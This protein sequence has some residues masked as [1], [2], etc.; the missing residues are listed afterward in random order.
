MPMDRRDPT[1]SLEKNESALIDWRDA[2]SYEAQIGDEQATIRRDGDGVA[3]T[4]GKYVGHADTMEEAKDR[5]TEAV[6]YSAPGALSSV[7]TYLRVQDLARLAEEE[8]IWIDADYIE[9]ARASAASGF[10]PVLDWVE[11]DD[12]LTATWS[13]TRFRISGHRLRISG[14]ARFATLAAEHAEKSHLRASVS[15]FKSMDRVDGSPQEAA[16]QRAE[17]AVAESKACGREPAEL[18]KIKR[19]LS[20]TLDADD[21]RRASFG[22]LVFEAYPSTHGYALRI[23]DDE[24]SYSH[25]GNLASFD[26]AAYAAEQLLER[27]DEC[28]GGLSLAAMLSAE[29]ADVR[30][31][32]WIAKAVEAA[33]AVDEDLMGCPWDDMGSG[34]HAVLLALRERGFELRPDGSLKALWRE[35]AQAAWIDPNSVADNWSLEGGLR[36][37]NG[38]LCQV[39]RDQNT[40][41]GNIRGRHPVRAEVDGAA[42]PF[43]IHGTDDDIAAA[44]AWAEKKA[45]EL[46]PRTSAAGAHRVADEP[47][48]AA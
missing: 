25:S 15:F 4:V 47:T 39:Y 44:K 20:W 26:A 45:R 41:I 37:I 22:D 18:L 40:Q 8:G 29:K 24:S 38:R 30:R 31:Q 32:Y 13:D 36:I 3:I 5:L 6:S 19:V 46:G 21:H 14:H 7:E 9:Q 43:S 28:E 12:G 35:R 1:A 42:Q 11:G 23:R 10:R 2:E 27:S 16:K 34:V 48:G 17:W 33:L